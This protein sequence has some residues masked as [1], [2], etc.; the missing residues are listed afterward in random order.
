MQKTRLVFFHFFERNENYLKNLLHFLI[1]GVDENCDYAI[2]ISGIC[3]VNLPI[4]ENVT[5]YYVE[6]INGDFGGYYQVFKRVK[7]LFL[8][9]YYFFVNCSVRGPFLPP[10]CDNKWWVIFEKNL[11]NDIGLVGTAINFLPTNNQ[12]YKAYCGDYGGSSAVHIQT[13]AYAMRYDV[14]SYLFDQEFYIQNEILDK[15]NLIS[16][17]EIHLTQKVIEGGWGVKCI[18][19]EF[20]AVF[21]SNNCEKS[22]NK[23]SRNGDMQ[24]RSAY[25]GRTMHP[26][27][28]IFVQTDRDLFTVEYLN[29]LA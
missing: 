19:Q 7:N 21:K 22:I 26:Y 12:Q 28:I 5:Y 3:S 9:K 8:Y 29:R 25:F 24:F 14:F 23:T 15:E 27:E 6:N 16:R 20:N 1:F 18:L 2:A 10:S 11:S 13:T 17:Y 4:I